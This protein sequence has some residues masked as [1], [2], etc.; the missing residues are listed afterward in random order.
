[1]SDLLALLPQ[2]KHA[3]RKGPARE[4]ASQPVAA[5][6]IEPPAYGNRAG[7]VPRQ[8]EDFGDGGAFPEILILQYPL[9]LGRK[10][11]RAV[12]SRTAP[13]QVDSEGNIKYDMILR[14]NMRKDVT[15]YSSYNDLVE[16]ELPESALV[17]PSLEEVEKVAE[18][19]RAALMAKVQAKTAAAQPKQEKQ[20]PVFIR[21]TPSSTS[22]QHNSG[23][24]QRIIRLQEMPRDPLE[25]P[26]FVHKKVPTG[27]GSPP[28]PVM[29]SPPRKVTAADQ[30]NWKIPP[31]VSNWKNIKGYT[32][33]LDKR[34][35]ADGRGLQEVQINDR[36]AKLSESLLIAERTAR[37]EIEARAA[38]HRTVARA[39]R[40]G[41]EEELRKLAARARAGAKGDD[42]DN[43]DREEEDYK[44]E[45]EEAIAERDA[46]EELRKDRKREM[47]RELRQEAIAA[48]TKKSS[49]SKSAR[50]AERD[51]S[52]KIALGQTVK[53][54]KDGLFDQRLFNQAEGMNA[55]FRGEESYDV[56]DKPLF[57]GA[58]STYIYR[59]KKDGEGELLKDAEEVSEKDAESRVSKL[60]E[61]GT[62]RFQADRGFKGTEEGATGAPRSQPVQFEK[63]SE[64]LFGLGE[65]L[66]EA[67]A[68]GGGGG[69][70]GSKKRTLDGIGG[71]GHLTAAA[72]GASSRAEDY[73][74][75]NAHAPREMQF[76]EASTFSS[77]SSSSSRSDRDR[78]ERG[79]SDR[80][81]DRRDRD[82]DSR[83][84]RDD[85]D[86]RSKRHKR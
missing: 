49:K 20:E 66:G 33:P 82:R 63:E 47:K 71:R 4:Q 44:P 5:T 45:S 84:S 70:G 39:Q 52:E 29:H 64:D 55:G 73:K 19:T 79:R 37:K 48:E 35:A 22:E 38:M 17:K 51:V 18:R 50:E 6:V 3:F 54:N 34:L 7:F 10:D 2:P 53:G 77:S 36:F 80:D 59:A 12:T 1:M 60:L 30:A 62:A 24:S 46:R 27:P 42:D 13:L 81:S 83:S 9:D 78:S 28:P 23:A 16:K 32:I 21:Y 25:P 74:G 8:V 56:Y 67:R 72:G 58:A 31:C 76:E 86:D 69:D 40:E 14:Q 26:R 65:L 75:F 68:G 43:E 41:Q 11:T 85:G 61:K 57:K 15:M